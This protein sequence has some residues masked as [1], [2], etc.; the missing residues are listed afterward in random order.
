MPPNDHKLAYLIGTAKF[1]L[2]AYIE[3]DETTVKLNELE[4]ELE[5]QRAIA[6]AFENEDPSHP[7]VR[8]MLELEADN[9]RRREIQ[10]RE[11]TERELADI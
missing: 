9:A 10:G 4:A 5:R 6:T 1:D 11:N 8:R 2:S 7:L 3:D